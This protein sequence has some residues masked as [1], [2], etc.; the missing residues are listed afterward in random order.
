M[1]DHVHWWLAALSFALGMALTF[2]LLVRPANAKMPAWV[3]AEPAPGPGE[4][5]D[6]PMMKATTAEAPPRKILPDRL[7]LETADGVPAALPG[8]RKPVAKD[9]VTEILPIAGDPE[10]EQIP[11]VRYPVTEKTP[12]VRDA[13][14]E[15]IPVAK[16]ALTESIPVAGS[17]RQRK[18]R[19]RR[20]PHRRRRPLRR[21][22][23]QRGRFLPRRGFLLR[24]GLQVRKGR[25]RGPQ[26]PRP[27]G[28]ELRKNLRRSRF[29][30]QR[31]AD[32]R[33]TAD[34]IRALWSRTPCG[35]TL[36]AAG[37]RDGR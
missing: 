9:A 32:G 25:G 36:M 21:R 26:A 18:R 35:P 22:L 28:C 15:R 2:T 16:D 3:L 17:P 8:R 5:P 23:P 31:C 37:P 14:T 34:A 29:R 13:M 10:T 19:R 20:H 30:I 7:K 24:R 11:V 6:P 27:S 33:H 4:T 12:V 1:I